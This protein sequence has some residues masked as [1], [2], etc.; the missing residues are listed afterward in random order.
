MD[1][2]KR[3]KEKKRKKIHISV[4]RLTIISRSVERH[5]FKSREEDRLE[6]T[7]RT[8]ATQVSQLHVVN[9]R[10]VLTQGERDDREKVAVKEKRED[11]PG[12]RPPPN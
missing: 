8:A 2:C 12:S 9:A 1:R 11:A 4:S 6:I 10:Q 7:S 5:W 3:D